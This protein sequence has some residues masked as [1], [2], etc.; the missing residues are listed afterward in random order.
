MGRKEEWANP[1]ADRTSSE[2][3]SSRRTTNFDTLLSPPTDDMNLGAE[4]GRSQ[5]GKFEL[6]QWTE[7]E[8]MSSPGPSSEGEQQAR[9]E[10]GRR[11]GKD[12]CCTVRQ[13]SA[14]T[15]AGRQF[16]T[17]RSKAGFDG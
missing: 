11:K 7:A 2:D 12:S 3:R 9:A 10:H 17:E 14:S 5:E 1:I 8:E 4:D 16:I 13:P 15:P 6:E